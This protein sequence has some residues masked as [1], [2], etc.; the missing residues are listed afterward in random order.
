MMMMDYSYLGSGQIYLREV[1]SAAGLLQV[2]NCSALSFQ[3]SE[4]VKEL[5]DY[6]QPGGGTYNEVRRISGVELSMTVHD[7][8]PANLTRA[9]YGTNS[10]VAAAATTNAAMGDGYIGAFL[11]FPEQAAATPAP[12]IRATKGRT[13]VARANSTAYT[14][15]QYLVPA[16]A[17]G[18]Y[19][20]VTTAGTSAAAPPTFPTTPGTTVTDGTAVLTCMG[21]IVLSA[22]TDYTL[23]T[24]GITLKTGAVFTAGEAVE[25][26]YTRIG[27][28]V[29]QALTN[30]G[31]EYEIVFI[32]LNEARSGKQTT[33]SAYRVK[34][35]A[36]Q[37][38]A[39]IGDDYAA[40]E[41]T[42]KL[43]K[44]TTKTGTGV[45]QYF[46]VEVVK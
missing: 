29:V 43:L 20:K 27:S 13:A 21:S 7:L 9:L 28:D 18:F 37:S 6:T 40:L 17:N 30:S 46:K 22:T 32:G 1:G 5:L 41:M 11:P 12:V 26:D 38:L 2:G 10:S 24:G 23:V 25:S 19:Y 35:G 16:A 4:D 31:K 14:V 15:G 36:A 3:I 45:S 39:L 33:V 8:S 44:D 42:G 34:L